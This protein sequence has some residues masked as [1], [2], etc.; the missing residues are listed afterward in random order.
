MNA[1]PDPGHWIS[2][3]LAAQYGWDNAEKGNSR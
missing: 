3:D 1:G 2:L